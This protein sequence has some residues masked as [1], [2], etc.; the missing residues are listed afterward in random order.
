MTSRNA[1]QFVVA[2]IVL[3]LVALRA[4][5]YAQSKADLWEAVAR[6]DLHTLQRALESGL[7]P[8]VREPNGATPLIVAAMFGHT[9]LVRLLIENDAALDVQNNDGA[10]A[11]YVASLFG[12]PDAVTLLLKE[13]AARDTRNNDGVTALETVSGPWSDELRGLYEFLGSIFQM[14]L[15]IDR[16]RDVR[17]EIRALLGAAR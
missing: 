14:E 16:I 11:L 7:D 10:T 2:M 9:D 13:G 6:G 4:P 8:D 5:I 1:R 17:P 3:S 15:D 12:H